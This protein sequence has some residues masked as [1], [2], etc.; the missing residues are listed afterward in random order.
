VSV[1]ILIMVTFLV[2]VQVLALLGFSNSRA[3]NEASKKI[4]RELHELQIRDRDRA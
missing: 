1:A 3:M 4:A 2:A